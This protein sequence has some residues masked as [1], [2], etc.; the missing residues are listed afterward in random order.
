[1]KFPCYAFDCF[2]IVE[3]FRKLAHV[4]KKYADLGDHEALFPLELGYFSWKSF[5]DAASVG[6][7][8]KNFNFGFY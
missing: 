2:V 8:L 7:D 1:M 4:I 3:L 6:V 5:A